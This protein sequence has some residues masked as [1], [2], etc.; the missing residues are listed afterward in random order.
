MMYA[1]TLRH[2]WIWAVV[3]LGKRIENRTWEPPEHL[4]GQYIAIHGAVPPKGK[5]EQIALSEDITAIYQGI[6]RKLPQG[7]QLE[8]AQ[9]FKH[10]FPHPYSSDRTLIEVENT[11]MPGIVAVARLE[12]V[13]TESDSPWFFGPYG[14]V[15][16]DVTV[17]PEPVACKGAQKF[18]KL[19]TDVLAQVRN[20]YRAGREDQ[21]KAA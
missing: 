3:H 6:L 2:P 8:L 21:R 4:I 19:P 16:A 20:G 17:L 1:L 15:L 13:I 7:E 18:W 14:F 12:R 10:R 5:S 9:Y 11:V